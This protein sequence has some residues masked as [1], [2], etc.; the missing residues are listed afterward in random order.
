[1]RT[2]NV[3]RE[4]KGETEQEGETERIECSREGKRFSGKKK[5]EREG[6]MEWNGKEKLDKE[7]NDD[8]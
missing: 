6:D 1:M 3:K 2:G 4:Q 5:E 8:R 7:W